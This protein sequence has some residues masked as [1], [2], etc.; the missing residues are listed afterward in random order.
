MVG[1]S[2]N[3]FVIDFVGEIVEV[4]ETE[5]VSVTVDVGVSVGVGVKVRVW[6]G[7]DVKVF[8]GA[9]TIGVII[10]RQGS[11]TSVPQ[12]QIPKQPM[13]SKQTSLVKSRFVPV[14]K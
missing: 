7:V 14:G 8:E 5:I 3:V 4:S 13:P 1:V 12:V 2:V 6:V 9:T 11:M 10:G